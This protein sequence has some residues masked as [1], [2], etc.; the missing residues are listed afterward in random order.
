MGSSP[1]S[2]PIDRQP[3]GELVQPSCHI[4]WPS[5]PGRTECRFPAPSP[6]LLVHLPVLQGHTSVPAGCWGWQFMRSNT[7][8]LSSFAFPSVVLP[9]L[10]LFLV[11]HPAVFSICPELELNCCRV[12]LNRMAVVLPLHE[13]YGRR[14]DSAGTVSARLP[15]SPCSLV[16]WRQLF[17]CSQPLV[18]IRR[19]GF[20]TS[21]AAY[22]P[23]TS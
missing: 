13:S 20:R 11:F 1:P 2:N 12:V 7:A 14:E 8:A 6:L 17:P 4:W 16:Y 10:P 18:A 23:L 3:S 19:T 9:V 15:T 5:T 21:A 22:V